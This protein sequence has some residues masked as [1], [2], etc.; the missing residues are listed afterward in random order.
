MNVGTDGTIWL[1]LRSRGDHYAWL[2][3]DP[4]GEPLDTVRV[5]RNQWILSASLDELWVSETDELDIPSVVRFRIE[6]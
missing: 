3:L 4:R 5:P 2:V 1:R 6:R